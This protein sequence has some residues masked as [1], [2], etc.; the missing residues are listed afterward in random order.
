MSY[1]ITIE[2]SNSF[3]NGSL[4]PHAFVTISGPGLTNP[5]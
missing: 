4:T 5:V 1:Q 3:V 2:I